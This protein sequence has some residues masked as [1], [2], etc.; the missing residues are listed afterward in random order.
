LLS[1][2]KRTPSGL[3]VRAPADCGVTWLIVFIMASSP[4]FHNGLIASLGGCYQLV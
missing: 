2:K 3:K 4:L 1:P